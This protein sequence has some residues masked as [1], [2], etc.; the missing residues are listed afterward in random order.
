LKGEAVQRCPESWKW[1]ARQADDYG[2][3]GKSFLKNTQK[4]ENAEEFKRNTAPTMRNRCPSE[5]K[6]IAVP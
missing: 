2:V 5:V 1:L 6:S 4:R 3:R